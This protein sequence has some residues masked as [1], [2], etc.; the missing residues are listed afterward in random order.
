QV[1]VLAQRQQRGALGLNGRGQVFPLGAA[2]GTEQ[3]RVRLFAN[4]EGRGG[5]GFAMV[6]DGEAADVRVGQRGGE[7]ELFGGGGEHTLGLFHDF[8]TEAAAGEYGDA[9]VLHEIPWEKD[10]WGLAGTQM[11]KIRGVMA[12]EAWGALERRMDLH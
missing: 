12:R 9:I 8:G 7:A 11:C 2:D 4:L 3:D 10:G 6:V 5:Q 1:E